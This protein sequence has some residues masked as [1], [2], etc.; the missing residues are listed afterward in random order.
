MQIVPDFTLP[1]D[2]PNETPEPVSPV[3]T[4]DPN[5]PAPATAT[6]A[7]TVMPHQGGEFTG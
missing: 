3:D 6:P 2:N 7:P 1:S 4:P 5:E